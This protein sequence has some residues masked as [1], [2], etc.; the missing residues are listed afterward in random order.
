[1]KDCFKT[2]KD[3]YKKAH[4]KLLSTGFGVTS[5][6][7]KAGINTIA[8][9]LDNMCPL[10]KEMN[11]LLGQRPNVNPLCRADAEDSHKL[12][13]SDSDTNSNESS[14][15]SAIDPSL[16]D[17]AKKKVSQTAEGSNVEVL[18][19]PHNPAQCEVSSFHTMIHEGLATSD[20][21]ITLRI[22]EINLFI[23]IQGRNKIAMKHHM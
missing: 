10:Y 12:S 7:R 4:T 11:K 8:Q 18:P 20:L 21:S 17:P 5:E 15:S 14:N 9:K 16:R 2:Y 23:R 3:K 6:D 13:S 22:R 19:I 1:M